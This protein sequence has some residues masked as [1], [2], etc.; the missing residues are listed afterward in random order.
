V[1][2]ANY[3]KW[4]LWDLASNLLADAE[5]VD[6]RNFAATDIADTLRKFQKALKSVTRLVEE[7]KEFEKPGLKYPRADEVDQQELLETV[8]EGLRVGWWAMQTSHNLGRLLARG[9]T[10]K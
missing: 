10:R 8:I 9:R 4:A 3:I 2:R 7:L 6:P 5:L 1:R